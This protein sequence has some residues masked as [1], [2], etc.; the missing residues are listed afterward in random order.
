MHLSINVFRSH[1]KLVRFVMLYLSFNFLAIWSTHSLHYYITWP[2]H[3]VMVR[4]WNIWSLTSLQPHLLPLSL[5]RSKDAK[6]V[7]T[8]LP[9]L[10]QCFYDVLWFSCRYYAIL[11]PMRAKYIC[12]RS[13]AKRVILIIWMLS[14]ILAI[15][16]IFGQVRTLFN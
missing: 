13:R 16:I 4:F 2:M 15:P 6:D 1:V 12:T 11:H 3:M 9:E 14:F 10:W 7:C 5:G 8:Y